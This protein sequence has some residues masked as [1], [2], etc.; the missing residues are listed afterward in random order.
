M[1]NKTPWKT[2]AELNYLS[3]ETFLPGEQR[4][5]TIKEVKQE[6]IDTHRGSVSTKWVL[7]FVEDSLPMILNS[8]NCDTIAKLYGSIYVEDWIGKR[9][10][11]FAPSINA[12][13][14]TRP[15]LRIKKIIPESNEPEYR[16][17]VCN[18]I[19]TKDL[20][21]SSIKKYGKPYCSGKCREQD[22]NGKDL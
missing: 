21:D 18:T 13:G 3:G 5:L 12:F 22:V 15:A 9:I 7:Y 1:E 19:I 14:E 4:V 8:T 2:L 6:S 10:Q 20:Y 16:C 11:V 17:C